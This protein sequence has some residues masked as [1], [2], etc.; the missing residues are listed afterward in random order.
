MT[1]RKLI[2]LAFPEDCNEMI[3]DIKAWDKKLLYRNTMLLRLDQVYEIA[4][5]IDLDPVD[6]VVVITQRRCRK[7]GCTDNDCSQC[8]SKT[9]HSI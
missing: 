3:S 4:E 9:G 7:C 1:L 8:I 5:I 2:T 6:M